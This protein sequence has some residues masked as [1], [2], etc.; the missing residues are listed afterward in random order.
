MDTGKRAAVAILAMTLDLHAAGAGELR[1]SGA[2]PE[3]LLE[4]F[5]ALDGDESAG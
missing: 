1:L 3:R 2:H 5:Q 4:D